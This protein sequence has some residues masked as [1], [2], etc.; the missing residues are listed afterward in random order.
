M[1][2][3]RI[4]A[5]SRD[6]RG[7]PAVRLALQAREQHI[8][9]EKATSNICTAQALLADVAAMY[10]CYHGPEGLKKIA[11]RIHLLTEIL[12]KGLERLGYNVGQAPRL[13]LPGAEGHAS[14][15]Q[16]SRLS[17]FDTIRV[18]LGERSTTDILKLAEAHR[19]NFR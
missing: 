7:R 8:R 6:S 17:C 14:L 4:F 13:S 18:D 19:M 1:V 16:A 10:A 3:G 9:R 11:Q 12:A 2:P 15:G 5:V